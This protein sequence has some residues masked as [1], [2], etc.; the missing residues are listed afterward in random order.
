MWPP[1]DEAHEVERPRPRW[2][3]RLRLT[4]LAVV[5]VGVALLFTPPGWLGM[6]TISPHHLQA[7]LSRG[8]PH[9]AVV[10]V[11]TATEFGQGHIPGA[12]SAPLHV[13]PFR[14]GSLDD[15]RGRELVVICLSGHRSRPA[16]LFLRMAG[17]DRVTNLAGGMAAWRARGYR[18]VA[19]GA[20]EGPA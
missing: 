7:R 8:D 1:A 14:L 15:L 19:A 6:G 3:W 20:P 4:A 10:D 5:A 12:V 2:K 17:F 16:G 13:L 18:S 9:L 11:R